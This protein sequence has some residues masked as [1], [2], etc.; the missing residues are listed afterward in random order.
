MKKQKAQKLEK[1]EFRLTTAEKKRI[2][3][4]ADKM[5]LTVSEYLRNKVLTPKDKSQFTAVDAIHIMTLATELV[6]YV[7]DRY[8]EYDD[9]YLRERVD[10]LWEMLQ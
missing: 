2:K 8:T 5:N 3:N 4:E 9:P 7:E 6:R 10:D 1:A